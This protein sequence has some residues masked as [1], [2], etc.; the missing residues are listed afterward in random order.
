MVTITLPTMNASEV[1][2]VFPEVNAADSV[3]L[4]ASEGT[5]Q[6]EQAA[7]DWSNLVSIQIDDDDALDDPD[8]SDIKYKL[9]GSWPSYNS[10]KTFDTA[11]FDESG[12]TTLDGVAGDSSVTTLRH[13]LRADISEDMTGSTESFDIFSNEVALDA[14]FGTAATALQASVSSNW[15]ALVAADTES[16]GAGI[17]SRAT[18]ASAN[19]GRHILQQV[20][21]AGSSHA[22]NAALVTNLA[23]RSA[24][25]DYAAVPLAAGDKIEFNITFEPPSGSPSG[26]DLPAGGLGGSAPGARNHVFKVEITLA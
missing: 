9:S 6:L 16:L 4:A 20:L 5:I 21:E 12:H 8:S 19:P 14:S 26:Q 23:A 15:S 10:G 7:T 3:T 13:A 11:T 22:G 25:T 2:S 24:S 1:L 18:A 17:L